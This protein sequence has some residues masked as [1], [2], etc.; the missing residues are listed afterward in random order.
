MRINNI[1]CL[2]L[3]IACLATTS[4]GAELPSP[5]DAGRFQEKFNQQP[6][7]PNPQPRVVPETSNI[8][9]PPPNAALVTFNLQ[10]VQINGL[11]ILAISELEPIWHDRLGKEINLLE[12]YKIA[13]AVTSRLRNAGYIL[14]I[15]IVPPQKIEGGKILLTVVEGYIEGV[16]IE[17]DAG[18]STNLLHELL[19]HVIK[20]RPVTNAVLER[21]LLLAKNLPGLQ[22]RS[23]IKPS[24]TEIGA[25]RLAILVELKKID[26]F[27]GLDNRGSR[28]IGPQELSLGLGINSMLTNADRTDLRFITTNTNTNELK[29]WQVAHSLKVG[30]EG[31][32][33]SAIYSSS[34]S[35]PGFTLKSLD[36]EGD[37]DTFSINYTHPLK[38]SRKEN[39]T[40]H[41]GFNLRSSDTDLL[42][43]NTAHERIRWF[44]VGVDYDLADSLNGINYMTLN[45]DKGLNVLGT[46]ETGSS[47][48]SRVNGRSDFTKIE[49]EFLRNQYLFGNWNF[50]AGL[51]WQYSPH[52]LLSAERYGV[53]GSQYGRAYN[54]SELTGDKGLAF[55]TEVRYDGL[56]SLAV[57]KNYQV[58]GFYDVGAVWNDKAVNE[59]EKLS[60]ASVGLGV[61]FNITKHFSGDLEIAKPLTR[62]VQTENDND[63]RGFF[64][65]TARF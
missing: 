20:E 6:I 17:G 24:D 45:L 59:R 43:V 44:S 31:D 51:S 34:K 2:P 60:L 16:D 39:L 8:L 63:I 12:V 50:L 41:G 52:S 9:A 42:G 1:R 55:K 23:V 56:T 37:A 33:V 25:A 30:A 58:Y 14:S 26:L 28:Y 46:T 49:G 65:L 40:L 4:Y 62:R 47:N 11:T 27:I 13:D 18:T 3:L 48:L 32:T 36:V 35:H 19:D 10:D 22:I 7:T 64:N 21:Y 53:G 15:A 29:F 57:L 5:A 38:V 61:R 54:S